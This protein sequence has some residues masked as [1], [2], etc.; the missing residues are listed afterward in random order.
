[1]DADLA[2]TLGSC[3]TRAEVLH[4]AMLQDANVTDPRDV[5]RRI[6]LGAEGRQ[7][8]ASLVHRIH[9]DALQKRSTMRLRAPQPAPR[10]A[11]DKRSLQALP[12]LIGTKVEADVERDA[13]EVLRIKR[14]RT[15]ESDVERHNS[16]VD[17]AKSHLLERL[18]F[19]EEDKDARTDGDEE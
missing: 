10:R 11:G 6:I 18:E 4:A 16:L 14:V 19:L 1:M 12:I 13:Q 15:S 9:A 3:R 8:Y 2:A 5:L 17:A 7:S